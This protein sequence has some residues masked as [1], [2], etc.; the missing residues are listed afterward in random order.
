VGMPSRPMKA[1]TVLPK[2]TPDTSLKICP[3]PAA[4]KV[5]NP[6]VTPRVESTNSPI[7]QKEVQMTRVEIGKARKSKHIGK[8][9]YRNHYDIVNESETDH[10]NSGL[11]E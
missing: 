4:A 3:T 7:Y 9:D 11:D 8:G 1:S 10:W 5:L 2:H 6:K